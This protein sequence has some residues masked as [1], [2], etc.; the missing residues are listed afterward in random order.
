MSIEKKFVD[1][2][3]ES[4]I[5]ILNGNDVWNGLEQN[6]V[7]IPVHSCFPSLPQGTGVSERLGEKYT[8]KSIQMDMN[9]IPQPVN[10]ESASIGAWSYFESPEPMR[11][12]VALVFDRQTNGASATNTEVWKEAG[13]TMSDVNLDNRKRFKIVRRWTLLFTPTLSVA[14]D[15]TSVGWT[16]DMKTIKMFK[17]MNVPIIQNGSGATTST[18]KSNSF[19]LWACVDGGA[20]HSLDDSALHN[21][22]WFKWSIRVRY[23]DA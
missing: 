9:I 6:A 17:R 23:T 3:S 1:Y 15:K 19:K 5:K 21:D 22:V 13:S 16:W 11:V 10:M 7:G 4:N 8:V 18:L 2:L 12:E 20:Y 14:P